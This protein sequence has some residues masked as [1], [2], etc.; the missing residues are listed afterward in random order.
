MTA[1]SPQQVSQPNSQGQA[2]GHAVASSPM[3]SSVGGMNPSPVQRPAQ[4][5]N[6]LMPN[7]NSVKSLVDNFP[8]LLELKRQGKLTPEQE[9]LVS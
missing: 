4:V 7:Q 5:P 2:Q 8:R 1:P 9:N 3:A 6:G